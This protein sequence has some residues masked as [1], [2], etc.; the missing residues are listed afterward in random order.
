MADMLF[1]GSLDF[2]VLELLRLNERIVGRKGGIA[3]AAGG[4]S[5]TDFA[6]A[7]MLLDRLPTNLF[8][9]LLHAM[10]ERAAD[11]PSEPKTLTSYNNLIRKKCIEA[12]GRR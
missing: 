11:K 9:L 4:P 7:V 3:P 5:A 10:Q 8:G 2:A 12:L 6:K 1:V